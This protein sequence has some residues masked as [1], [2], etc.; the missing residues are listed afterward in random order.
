MIAKGLAV[1]AGCILLGSGVW[2]ATYYYESTKPEETSQ[3]QIVNQKNVAQNLPQ[4]TVATPT[5]TQ[6]GTLTV[7]NLLR[8]KASLAGQPIQV[9]GTI[10]IMDYASEMRCPEDNLDCDTT[11]GQD[12]Y[13]SDPQTYEKIAIYKQ[14]KSYPC[15]KVGSGY[16]CGNYTSGQTVVVS[17]TLIKTQVPYQTQGGSSGS[18]QVVSWQD[19]YYLEIN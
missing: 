3:Q 11:L 15:T 6:T 1:I 14:G 8:A 18:P 16:K 13:L 9:Q 12:L 7:S 19:F 10:Q 2:A 5:N 4:N 17:A